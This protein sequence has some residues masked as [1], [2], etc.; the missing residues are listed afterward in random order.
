MILDD[1]DRSSTSSDELDLDVGLDVADEPLQEGQEGAEAKA[2]SSTVDSE[3]QRKTADIVRDVV[4][5][6]RGGPDSRP[7]KADGEGDEPGAKKP[8][9]E[10][11]NE[12]YSDVPFSKH[13]RFQQL[14][15]ER[16]AFRED[17]GRYR[18]VETFLQSNGLTAEQAADALVI[19]GL[20]Q[21]NPAEAFKRI[22]P[23]MLDLAI[24]AG[25]ILP[26]DLQ[27]Q[28]SRGE[29]QPTVALDLSRQRAQIASMQY[30]ERFNGQQRQT[31]ENERQQR[32]MMDT[33][34]TWE[35]ERRIKDPNYAAKAATVEKEVTY[36]QRL[37]GIPNT[38][39]GVRQMLARAYKAANEQ[40]RLAHPPREV[41]SQ[42]RQITPIRGG[43]TQAPSVPDKGRSTLD[44][45]R[46][47]QAASRA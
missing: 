29:L 39:D 10:P 42:R 27:G 4:G 17:A 21:S 8:P 43:Q 2:D 19:A 44:I 12:N 32:L 24:A 25:E 34:A 40:Y 47:V 22:K 5:K 11:D 9:K 30:A 14:L 38:Q 35:Q 45:I 16:T 18:N 15:R 7:G 37:E 46:E 26:D 13:P 41:P 6:E 36:L 3:T 20:A 31:Q 28:V 1:N 23:W 33:A